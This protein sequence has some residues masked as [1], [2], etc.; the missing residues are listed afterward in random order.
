MIYKGIL[1]GIFA[2]FSYSLM[3]LGMKLLDNRVNGIMVVFFRFLVSVTWVTIVLI[4][5]RINHDVIK[6]ST[7]HFTKYLI[8][9]FSTVISMICLYYSLKFVPLAN[10]NTLNLSYTIFIP[11]IGYVFYHYRTSLQGCFNIILGFI[12]ILRVGCILWKMSGGIRRQKS[13]W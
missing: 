1:F 13:S 7:A 2:A 12:G 6:L 3:T 11:I 9:S 5:K 10:A 4:H 8:R